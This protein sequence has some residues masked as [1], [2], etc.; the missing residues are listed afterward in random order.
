[1]NSINKLKCRQDKYQQTAFNY[2]E[3]LTETAY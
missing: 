2:T 1:V 3:E